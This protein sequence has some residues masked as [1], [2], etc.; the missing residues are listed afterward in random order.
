MRTLIVLFLIGLT[1]IQYITAQNLEQIFVKVIDKE[2]SEPVSFATI[3]IKNST[4][5]VIADYN[6]ELRIPVEFNKETIIIS[7]IGYEA[8]EI[9]LNNL[10]PNTLNIIEINPQIEALNPVFISSRNK[11]KGIDL[12]PQILVEKS[13]KLYAKEIVLR[14]IANIPKNLNDQAHSYV[15]YY[16]DYQLVDNEFHNLNEAILETFDSGINTS[17][18]EENK[19]ATAVYNFNQN[20]NFKQDTSLTKAYNGKTKYIRHSEILP[21]GG[22]EHTILSIHDPIRNFNFSTFSYVYRLNADFPDLHQFEKDKIV[23]LNNEPLVLITFKKARPH[24]YSSVYGLKSA[25][26]EYV[27]GSIYISLVDYSIHRFNYKVF[28]PR[29]NKVLFN[30]NLE[31]AR[32]NDNMYLNYITFNNAFVIGEDFELREEKVE[33]NEKEQAFYI[34]FNNTEDMLDHR[35]IKRKHFKFKLG[36]KNLK[37][38][39]AERTEKRIV[40]VMVEHYDRSLIQLNVDN[41]DDLSYEFKKIKDVY[42]REIYKQ[43]TVEGDQFREFFVQNVNES[44]ALSSDLIIMDKNLP[45]NESLLN[46]LPDMNQYWINSPL[47]NKKYRD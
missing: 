13:R 4:I 27:Q 19:V 33:F 37:T 35:T 22:N 5:G 14:A 29:S 40:K 36:T 31:Y 43:L 41:V 39:S 20:K 1:S 17:F 3:R 25:R 11:V 42:G 30:I 26:D 18:L 12:N 10:E 34:T 44:K 7:C 6:G 47:M 32:Q 46:N 28:I 45:I 8:Q 16:R 38:I 23:F 24:D 15:G 2:T 9:I 21:R